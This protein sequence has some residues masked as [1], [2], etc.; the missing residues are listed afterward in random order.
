MKNVKRS[1]GNKNDDRE[2]PAILV[3]LILDYINPNS[4]IWCPFDT[5][6][7]QFVKVLRKCDHKVIHTHIS[8]GEDFF[9]QKVPACDYI[10][11]NPPFSKKIDVFKR[12]FEIEKPF[13]MVMNLECLNYQ[14]VGNFFH[15]NSKQLQLLIP[16]KKVSFDGKTSSFNSSYFCYNMLPKDLLF[17]HLEHNNTGNNFSMD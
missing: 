4:T 3:R 8:Q 15:K 5:E 13:A 6:K 7:S 9:Q 14:E 11:S 2:T 16:D 1:M 10:I 17:V 12:L